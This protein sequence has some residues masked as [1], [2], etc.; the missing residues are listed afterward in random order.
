VNC[1]PQAL[2]EDAA[3]FE[4]LTLAELDWITLYLLCQWANQD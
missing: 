3:C 1:E 2:A 4:C